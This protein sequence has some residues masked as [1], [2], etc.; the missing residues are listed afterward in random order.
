MRG[1]KRQPE[2][3]DRRALT[4]TPRAPAWMS[5][6]ARDEWRRVAPDLVR[7]RVL[8]TPALGLLESYCSAAG[9]VRDAYAAIARDGAYPKS[10]SGA[11][12]RH[13]AFSTIQ[14]AGA[15]MRRLAAELAL[16]PTSSAKFREGDADA[17]SR[18]DL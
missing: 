13:P 17:W 4:R 16:S 3:D 1:R 12:K 14:Q 15:E 5:A 10:E 7:R 8:T 2:A 6:A 18:M 11:V 9:L